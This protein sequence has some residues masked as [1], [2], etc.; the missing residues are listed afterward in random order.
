[1]D[2][3]FWH[4]EFEF[5]IWLL[6]FQSGAPNLHF[7]ICTVTFRDGSAREAYLDFEMLEFKIGGLRIQILE[8][9]ICNLQNPNLILRDA[10]LYFII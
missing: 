3:G 2:F 9:G 10:N 5:R 8:L 6:D 1:M 7:R 4:L